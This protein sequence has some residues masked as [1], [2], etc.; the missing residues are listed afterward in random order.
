M[1]LAIWSFRV[2]QRL[3]GCKLICIRGIYVCRVVSICTQELIAI[4][5]T[6][7][8]CYSFGDSDRTIAGFLSSHS[9]FRYYQQYDY[10]SYIQTIKV[11]EP[12][13]CFSVEPVVFKWPDFS[14]HAPAHFAHAWRA[15]F[16]LTPRII[17][18]K[19]ALTDE[20]RYILIQRR[21]LS[22][23]NKHTQLSHDPGSKLQPPDERAGTLT[24]QPIRLA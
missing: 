13:E 17:C 7:T 9:V 19:S 20:P 16:Y 3:S 24:T 15:Q 14:M 12:P 18:L 11:K 6:A 23:T 22:C 5:Y 10:S 4:V 2:K 8:T 21:C 1:P